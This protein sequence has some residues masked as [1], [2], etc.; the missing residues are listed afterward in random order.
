M[1]QKKAVTAKG[2]K[3][4]NGVAKPLA[5]RVTKSIKVQEEKE[6]VVA[7]SPSKKSKKLPVKEVPQSSEEDESD[8]EKQSDEQAQD[9]SDFETGEAADFIE[10]EAEEDEED[11]S[12]EEEDDD[13]E[14][15]PGEVSKSEGADE[16]E[17][18]DDD[19]EAPVEKPVSKKSEKVSEKNSGIPKVHVNKIPQGTPHNQILF[20]AN[21]PNEYLHKDL[22]ALFAKFGPLTALQRF[23]NQNNGNTVLIAFKTPAG[24]ENALQAKAKALTLGDNVLS[25]SLMRNKEE[26]NERTVTVGLIGTNV[27]KT[28]LKTYI[29]KVAPVESVTF[30]ANRLNP[31]AFVRLV[32]VDDVP[33]VLKLHS[34]ELFSRFITVCPLKQNTITRTSEHTLIIENVG[35]HESYSSDA[36]EKIFKK[37]G[38]VKEVDVLC[39]KQVLAFVTFKESDA[40]TKALAE[41]DGKTI[42]NVEFK[43][44]RFADRG[45]SILVTNLTSVVSE[46]DLRKVFND[47]G[48]I[49]TIQMLGNRAIIQFKDVDGFCKSFLANES[50]VNNIPIFIEPNSAL[51][52]RW[53]KQRLAATGQAQGPR[54]FQKDF[55]PNFGKKPF[56]KRPA[57]ENGGKSF[58]KR[59]RF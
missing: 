52:H 26:D 4:T 46:A 40:A 29:E 8:V 1:A 13:D 37:F 9:D 22:V 19:D 7:K 20:V 6:T 3:A 33:K 15:E 34:T 38:D 27:T 48:E 57:Q 23:T 11:N 42:N 10:D 36:L 14:L 58:N 49:E 41:V 56:N 43:V 30:S 2:K 39:S 50:L 24:V 54:K 31:K 21:L 32:S 35:R 53:L 44:H 28:D 55:K 17:N 47:S 16:V 12:D 18:S 59:A 51:K 45:R 5:K 25:V